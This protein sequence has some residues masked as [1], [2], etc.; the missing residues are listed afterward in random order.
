MLYHKQVFWKKDFDIES[1]KLIKSVNRFSK[2]LQEYFDDTSE[3]RNFNA[4][5]IIRIVDKLKQ[6]D[7]V[8]CFEVETD[9]HQLQKCVI[10][11]GFNGKKDICIV[12]RKGLVVTAWLCNKD[13]RHKTLDKS[14]YAK[15]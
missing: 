13:D 4:D 1:A 14:K 7:S 2:H 6:F 10:R 8:K 3:R 11:C 5:D 15:K 9:G 12:F